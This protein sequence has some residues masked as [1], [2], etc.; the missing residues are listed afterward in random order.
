MFDICI[1]MLFMYGTVYLST[2]FI[3]CQGKILSIDTKT[4]TVLENEKDI[5]DSDQATMGYIQI[6][7]PH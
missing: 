4:L 3:Y 6:H 7:S 2:I 5:L 1:S